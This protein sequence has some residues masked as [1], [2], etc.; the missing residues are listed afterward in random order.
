MSLVATS[1]E[2]EGEKPRLQRTPSS[3]IYALQLSEK[4]K[5]IDLFGK[6]QKQLL[7]TKQCKEGELS[8]AMEDPETGMKWLNDN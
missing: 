3:D 2:P 6:L 8:A 1:A 4:A 7:L 5:L